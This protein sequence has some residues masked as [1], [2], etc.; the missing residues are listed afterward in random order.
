M[1]S[2][3]LCV[4]RRAELVVS[5]IV[6]KSFGFSCIPLMSFLLWC[7]CRSWLTSAM[8][9]LNWRSSSR[10]RQQSWLTPTAG[11]RATKLKSRNYDSEWRSWRR[12]WAMLKMRWEHKCEITTHTTKPLMVL[13]NTEKSG[14]KSSCLVLCVNF[15]TNLYGKNKSILYV[16]KVCVCA[17][18]CVFVYVHM[19]VCVCMHP[20]RW[21]P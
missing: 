19:N 14:K 8:F 5:S 13:W 15:E 9:T 6:K 3:F 20:A 7:P 21:V 12:S 1:C 4:L 18:V 2:Q 11:W 10:R 17:C 16:I